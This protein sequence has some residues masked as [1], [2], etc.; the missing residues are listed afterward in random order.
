MLNTDQ[1]KLHEVSYT[2]IYNV[3]QENVYTFRL[4]KVQDRTYLQLETCFRWK[5][6]S[7]TSLELSKKVVQ[8]TEKTADNFQTAL[9]ATEQKILASQS[10]QKAKDSFEILSNEVKDRVKQGRDEIAKKVSQIR[11]VEEEEEEEEKEEAK[12]NSKDESDAVLDGNCNSKGECSGSSPPPPKEKCTSSWQF[13][14][15]WMAETH[16]FEIVD[17]ID[18]F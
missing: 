9:E 3:V 5:K 11:I 14:W 4:S 13:P 1:Y 7:T 15:V 16:T 18:I 6:L 10:L 8:L 12:G 2:A 17:A